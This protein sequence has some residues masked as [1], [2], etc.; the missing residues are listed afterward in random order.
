MCSSKR[1]S[2]KIYLINCGK[3]AEKQIKQVSERFSHG[4]EAV[5]EVVIVGLSKESLGHMKEAK[6]TWPEAAFLALPQEQ[7]TEMIQTAYE[8]GVEFVLHNPVN[9]IELG[10]LLKNIEM[11][12]MMKWMIQKAGTDFCDLPPVAA[13]KNG[14]SRLCDSDTDSYIRRLKGILRDIGILSEAGSKDIINIAL[15]L[16]EHE[17]HLGDITLRELCTNMGEKT[18]NVEQRIRRA[19]MIGLTNL[20]SRGLND[21]ADPAFNEYAGKLYQFEQIKKEMDY[22]IGKSDEHGNVRIR[23]FLGILLEYCKEGERQG[24]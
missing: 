1:S 8:M 6:E 2:M 23:K 7:D 13:Q 21:Y 15:Y 14:G 9:E 12:R 16:L 10:H 19:A 20:A 17:I 18:K 24:F 11:T 5:T 3:T 22:V 4:A